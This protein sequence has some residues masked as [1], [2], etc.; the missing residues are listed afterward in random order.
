MKSGVGKV[1]WYHCKENEIG[2]KYLPGYLG[3]FH[4]PNV[5]EFCDLE[6]ITGIFMQENDIL[7][8]WIFWGIVLG[9]FFIFALVLCCSKKLRQGCAEKL[10]NCLGFQSRH[11]DKDLDVS[12]GKKSGASKV[13]YCFNVIWE[14]VGLGLIGLGTLALS[15]VDF[16][17]DTAKR[18]GE[19]FIILGCAI[20]FICVVGIMVAH[21]DKPTLK[22]WIY[23]IITLFVLFLVILL[24]IAAFAMNDFFHQ[25]IGLSWFTFKLQF[26]D[27]WQVL[28]YTEALTQ[29]ET[30]IVDNAKIVW[31]A[32]GFTGVSLVVCVVC[33]G[34]ILW[35]HNIIITLMTLMNA[36]LTTTGILLMIM[37][38]SLSSLLEFNTFVGMLLVPVFII[39]TGLLGM[40]TCHKQKVITAFIVCAWVLIVGLTAAGILLM[41]FK[42]EVTQRAI[43]FT[44]QNETAV[45]LAN[46]VG[47]LGFGTWTENYVEE[48]QN[49]I[50]VNIN[51]AGASCLT[52]APILVIAAVAAGCV[53]KWQKKR[54]P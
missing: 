22:S 13:L 48:I 8:E 25:V 45:K 4:C 16:L 31:P 24:L 17:W 27:S 7:Y 6:E 21:Q 54:R 46:M 30:V 39:I 18:Q 2:K 40:C 38:A 29:F 36:V 49:F 1:K 43:S 5:T 10:K 35:W 20:M 15:G 23:F 12:K 3:A 14:I 34:I 50:R 41:L 52:I 42:E 51:A 9:V 19:M 26:P 47:S 11:K 33:G 37:L 53:L 32:F 44:S 28:N